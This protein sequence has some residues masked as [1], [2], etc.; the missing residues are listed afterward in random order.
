LWLHWF[1]AVNLVLHF[2]SLLT[3]HKYDFYRKIKYFKMAKNIKDFEYYS[4][5]N[6]FMMYHGD[7]SYCNKCKRFFIKKHGAQSHS[8]KIHNMTLDGRELNQEIEITPKLVSKETPPVENIPDED[9]DYRRTMKDADLR[10]NLNLKINQIE[11]MGLADYASKLR[12]QHNIFSQQKPEKPADTIS[13][14]MLLTLWNNETDAVRQ[15]LFYQLYVMKSCGA[16]DD[17]IISMMLMHMPNTIP[18]KPAEKSETQKQLELQL[19]HNCIENMNHDPLDD[20]IRYQKS[21]GKKN[22]ASFVDDLAL[23]V[24][25]FKEPKM[26]HVGILPLPA[27]GPVLPSTK[28]TVPFEI[29]DNRKIPPV[30]QV[31]PMGETIFSKDSHDMYFEFDESAH[32]D[33]LNMARNF[34][35]PLDYADTSIPDAVSN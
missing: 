13:A 2:E 7:Q 17:D 16:S 3:M 27:T 29:T 23:R 9:E 15:N 5:D 21:L 22:N 28:R 34:A 14:T 6:P 30:K 18:E 19:A 10:I 1:W 31:F 4:D 33:D 12:I 24:E 35:I 25:K 32:N 20:F 26:T 11:K 8:S